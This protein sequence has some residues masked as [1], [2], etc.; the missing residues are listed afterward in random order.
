MSEKVSASNQRVKK[1]STLIEIEEEYCKGC[2]YC[3]EICPKGV[4]AESLKVNKKGYTLPEVKNIEE[5]I[6]C[7]KCEL[8]CPEMAISIKKEEEK[9]K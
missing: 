7:K 9:K 3:I 5:C 6:R 8:I 4:L 2:A 1:N